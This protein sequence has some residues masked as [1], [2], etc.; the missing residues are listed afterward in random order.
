MC[1]YNVGATCMVC[2]TICKISHLMKTIERERE[3]LEAD[4][5]GILVEYLMEVEGELNFAPRSEL[6]CLES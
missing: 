4:E 6:S 2:T 1:T 5:D 3:K